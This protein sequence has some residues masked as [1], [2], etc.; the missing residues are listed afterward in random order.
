MNHLPITFITPWYGHFAGGA[1]VAAR[2][3]CEQLARREYHVQVLTTCCRSAYD[4]W[5]FDTL[6]S[7]SQE[8]NGVIVHRF[9]VNPK[10]ANLF[11]DVNYRLIHGMEVNEEQQ[12][13]FVR[14]SINSE[15]L[16]KYAKANTEGHLVIA[17]PYT[18]GLIYSV[19]LALEGSASIMP[20]LHDEPQMRW[21]TTAE[22]F[23]KSKHIFF[24]TEEEKT[25]AIRE[26]GHRI[27]RRLVESPVVGVGVE[28]L[29]DI[30]RI[31]NIKASK[32]NIL[33]KYELPEKFFIYMG[34]KDIGK[35]AVTLI[36]YFRDYR[37]NGGKASLLFLGGGDANLVPAEDG[38]I[39]LGFVPEEDKYLILSQ[40][41]GLINLSENESFS[42]VIM[43][44][45]LCGVPV[46]VSA[47][48]EVTTAHC[49]KSSGGILVSSSEEFCVALNML[50]TQTLK[51]RMGLS[52]K[53]Y[54]QYN[55]SWDCV[56]DRLLRGAY[57]E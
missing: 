1:E 41:L 42:L 27:G 20:C 14:N 43:E 7:G 9:P 35:N 34:R 39:D 30:K 46:I 18:Q 22:M 2:S 25:V 3:F 11:H 26:H 37:S 32:E 8:V 6:P 53:R 12:R 51:E 29:A 56:L 48:C 10:D 50:E 47:L 45:W 13:Q 23:D 44:A 28:V 49:R 40:A 15:Y 17:M 5:W 38:F 57:R 52:G 19:I 55:Y 24:L 4:S 21:K 54:T 36:R 31:M 33:S 16:V